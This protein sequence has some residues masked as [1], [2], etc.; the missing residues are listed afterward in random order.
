[1]IKPSD[2]DWSII[3]SS[4]DL[5]EERSTSSSADVSGVPPE[6]A[7]LQTSGVD[8]ENENDQDDDVSQSHIT[9]T[10]H[11]QSTILKEKSPTDSCAN[12][13]IFPHLSASV[14]KTVGEPNK[15]FDNDSNNTK[16]P[17]ESEKPVARIIS[18]YENLSQNTLK[19]HKSIKHQSDQ[20]YKNV[21]K[22]RLMVLN[23]YVQPNGDSIDVSEKGVLEAPYVNEQEREQDYAMQLPQN[24]DLNHDGHREGM[25]Q[26][27][28]GSVSPET[29]LVSNSSSDELDSGNTS[30]SDVFSYYR[31]RVI[32]ASTRI[33]NECVED[34][35]V[36][37]CNSIN[38]LDKNSEYLLY[39]MA[40][41]IAMG[42]VSYYAYSA[43]TFT[44][45]PKTLTET[46]TDDLV[47]SLR[48]LWDNI[49]YEKSTNSR[50]FYKTTKRELRVT[51]IGNKL[52]NTAKR[53][54]NEY[55]FKDVQ[56]FLHAQARSVTGIWNNFKLKLM[57][58]DYYE[59][60]IKASY[61][62]R[63]GLFWYKDVTDR[64]NAICRKGA[65]AAYKSFKSGIFWCQQEAEKQNEILEKAAISVFAQ[66]KQFKD[67]SLIKFQGFAKDV[68]LAADAFSYNFQLNG[69]CKAFPQRYSVSLEQTF[70]QAIRFTKS[71]LHRSTDASQEI[72]GRITELR[73]YYY[74]K[75]AG[76]CRDYV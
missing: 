16:E 6:S 4:S 61:K 65:S 24:N 66:A 21:A 56:R 10:S 34:L 71:Y 19:L 48:G 8:D 74:C 59:Y 17:A 52:D 14:D 30:T 45:E 46:M 41:L 33:K 26:V 64:T 20:L 22:Q 28:H 54:V 40:C 42:S 35:K 29:S 51:K 25:V 11:L 69:M 60:Y 2:E 76:R 37:V 68:A 58:I 36:S 50:W 32:D 72:L 49:V 63:D 9:D 39:F 3:S 44:P 23:R 15:V 67:L 7:D 31:A 62:V 12:T 53:I 47:T 75:W 27:N 70:G 5:D 38:W 13:P 18:F 1:M 73:S 43:L 55:N 57:S